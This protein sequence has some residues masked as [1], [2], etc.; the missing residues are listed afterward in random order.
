MASTA[1][2]LLSAANGAATKALGWA[3]S[4]THVGEVA[5]LVDRIPIALL[6][7]GHCLAVAGVS[8]GRYAS[9]LLGY[10]QGFL[11]A[12]GGGIASSIFLGVPTANVI[13]ANN[14]AVLLWT[15]AWWVVNHNPLALVA[16]GLDL[17]PVGIF[18]RVSMFHGEAERASRAAFRCVAACPPRPN[19]PSL[20]RPL[21]R[22]HLISVS[23]EKSACRPPS[24][25]CAPGWWSSR[26][27]WPPR[28]SPV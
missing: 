22:R 23:V 12:F 5:P 19:N 15:A 14:D 3:A 9:Q 11:M 16:Q 4:V 28:C 24:R 26:W 7:V 27:L 8:R 20:A 13:F 1:L 2:A 6:L 10:V 25:S 17:A 21:S 18:S